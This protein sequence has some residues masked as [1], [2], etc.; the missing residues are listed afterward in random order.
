MT[1]HVREADNQMCEDVIN[2]FNRYKLVQEKEQRILRQTLG[3]KN[4][5]EDSNKAIYD[6]LL[7]ASEFRQDLDSIHNRERDIT[8]LLHTAN[9]DL[10]DLYYA[11]ELFQYSFR[12]HHALV[13]Y[14]SIV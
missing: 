11:N 6:P 12:G 13:I 3:Q 7:L 4:L 1:P 10:D 8:T 14:R 2:N 5:D 9:P